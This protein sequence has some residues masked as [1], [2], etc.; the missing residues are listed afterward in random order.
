[1][2]RSRLA[3]NPYE[4]DPLSP[5]VPYQDARQTTFGDFIQ[6]HKDAGMREWDD[7]PKRTPLSRIPRSPHMKNSQ[8]EGNANF[9]NRKPTP[10]AIRPQ[11][12]TRPVARV[13][14]RSE[15][16]PN[17]MAQPFPR[18][19][20]EPGTPESPTLLARK[21][22]IRSNPV[23]N[24]PILRDAIRNDPVLRDAIRSNADMDRDFAFPSTP[25]QR[26]TEYSI[27]SMHNSSPS[28]RSAY[29]R[30]PN[31]AY[32]QSMDSRRSR[33]PTHTPHQDPMG[34]Y[35]LSRHLTRSPTKTL[36]S[37]SERSERDSESIVFKEYIPPS[38]KKRSR[39]PM[40][41]MFGDRGWLGQSPDE[42]PG[43]NLH[44]RKNSRQGEPK[45]S[46][47]MGKLMNKLEELVGSFIRYPH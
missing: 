4:F 21:E 5:E 3:V 14:H 37:V 31:S 28:P 46:T 47:I 23:R 15:S 25:H 41:K 34:S 39:S 36:D 33:S 8:S 32:A 44:S 10:T 12:P 22:F 11:V 19:Q 7:I 38:P 17:L 2:P 42:K 35:G 6:S 40:K 16:S 24:D 29:T 9:I 13:I 18:R 30:P 1:M 27:H 43:Q 20:K 26:D 45:K